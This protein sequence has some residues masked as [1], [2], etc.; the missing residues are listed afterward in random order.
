MVMPY[1]DSPM[2]VAKDDLSSHIDE[3][4]HEEKTA[5]KHLL[6]YEHASTALCGCY[7]HDT[8]KVR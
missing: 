1:H 8:E 2:R 6:M 3:L 4:V 5:L 7:K